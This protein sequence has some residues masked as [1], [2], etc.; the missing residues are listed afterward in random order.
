[1]LNHILCS[2][3]V[4][5]KKET[6]KLEYIRVLGFSVNGQKYLNKIKNDIKVPILNKY[7]TKTYKALEIEKRVTDIYSLIYEDISKEEIKN[8]PYK[9]TD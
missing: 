6:N 8:K 2:Y 1:M 7:D 4:K 5:E 9:N 3:T